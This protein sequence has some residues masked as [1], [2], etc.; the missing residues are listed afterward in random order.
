MKKSSLIISFCLATFLYIFIAYLI[1][2]DNSSLFSLDVQ[3]SNLVSLARPDWL[4]GIMKF[5]TKLGDGYVPVIFGAIICFTLAMNRKIKDAL[6]FSI[7][8]LS[9]LALKS[10]NKFIIDRARPLDG[11]VQVTES[12]FP[13]GH[14]MLSLLFFSLCAF[15]MHSFAKTKAH[16]HL[17]SGIIALLVLAIGFSRIYL[18]VHWFS[19][20]IGGYLL[21]LSV[22]SLAF[23]I[24]K[25]I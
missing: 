21:G 12:S 1:V 14:A 23:L 19:D 9:G 24:Y 5:I 22:L 2:S 15:Y 6:F 4:T 13:S 20:V 3:V 7:I 25:K 8:M 16:N 17:I 11:L 10:V 18:G